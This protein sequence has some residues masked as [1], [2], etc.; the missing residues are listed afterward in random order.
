MEKLSF[1]LVLDQKKSKFD[2]GISQKFFWTGLCGL[3]IFLG[4]NW[5]FKKY[6]DLNIND[7]QL[8]KYLMYG[9][10]F[11]IVIGIFY[12]LFESNGNNRI[13]KGFIT[14]DENEITINNATRYSLSEIRNLK[15]T[16]Y[17]H[18]GRYINIIS[19]GDPF[20]S[21]GGDNYVEFDYRNNNYKFQFVVNSI[22]HR[23]SLM[24]KTIPKMKMK[25]DIKY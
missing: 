6:T 15:F 5:I 9:L 2:I 23:K 4:I 19:D 12:G 20:R 1:D 10:L 22:A 3:S 17:D 14:F 25:T 18:K 8:I 16:G 13:I 11:C 21:Y 7:F 24:E